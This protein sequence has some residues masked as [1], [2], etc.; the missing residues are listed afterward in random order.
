MSNALNVPEHDAEA[1]EPLLSSTVSAT[2][3]SQAKNLAAK[4]ALWLIGICSLFM[5]VGPVL[6]MTNSYLMIQ[7]RFPYPMLL[8]AV[9]S[10]VGD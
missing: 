5:F 1:A 6:I 10:D 7:A 9:S 3:D 4:R 8:C 2:G